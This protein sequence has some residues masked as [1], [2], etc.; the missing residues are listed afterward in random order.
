MSEP[1]RRVTNTPEL[2]H[3]DSPPG[4]R[5]RVIKAALLRPINVLML[6]IGGVFFALT[7]SWWI[8]PLTLLTYSA[9]VFLAA[10]DPAFESRVLEGRE[11][12]SQR[13]AADDNSVSPERRARWLPRGETR[14]KIEAALHAYRQIVTAIEQSDDVA[15]AVLEDTI[16]KLHM[17]ADRMV[18]AAH[19]REKAAQAIRELQT[20]SP[21]DSDENRTRTLRDLESELQSANA[22]ISE[23]THKLQTLRAS[24]VRV[25]IDSGTAARATAAELNSSLDE[26]NVRLEALGETMSGSE[27]QPPDG[28]YS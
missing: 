14:Q 22:E 28:S 7:S 21:G 5:R 25:S 17:A 11:A 15:R 3:R 20:S 19:N 9:L 18:V 2:P 10:R 12:P 6:A 24:V 13:N 26:L 1:E 27:E 8:L 23:T 4:N 16:P